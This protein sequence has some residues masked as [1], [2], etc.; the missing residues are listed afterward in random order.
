VCVLAA[1]GA[2][3]LAWRAPRA[4]LTL[5]ALFAPYAVFHL[6]FQETATT[7]YALP[8][9]PAVAYL[10]MAAVEGLPGRALPVTALGISAISLVET[11][12]ASI[13]YAHDGAPVFRAFDDMAATA[14]GGDPVTVIALHA[15]MRRASEWAAPIL[16]ARVVRAPHGREWLALVS[17]WKAEPSARVWFVADP[18][19]TDLALFDARDRDLARAY[20][21]EFVEP[22][23]VGGGAPRQRRLVSHAAASLDARS[24][25]V[26]HPGSRRRH[27]TRSARTAHRA[28]DRVAAPPAHGDDG[29]PRRAQPVGRDGDDGGLA[30]LGRGR[31]IPDRAAR[32]FRADVHHSC[33]CARRRA[34]LPSTRSEIGK[35]QRAAGLART[36]RR[37]AARR[38][39]VRL[40]AWLAGAGV[41][42][43]SNAT[44]GGG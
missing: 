14:H 35:R 27:R 40:R 21:W 24:R 13:S 42:T 31:A 16:P 18:D 8:L 10:A 19:R 11:V 37:A 34:W 3:R 32:V 2:A 29:G 7:R 44:R 15:Q 22:P 41:S 23:F 6:L 28:V 30:S 26:A 39:D 20:R 17:L 9:V 25:L 4:L 38:A 1:A 36:V 5:L 33:R 43:A 12:P